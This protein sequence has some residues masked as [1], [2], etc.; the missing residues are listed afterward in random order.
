M[1][2]EE[3]VR[4]LLAL[5]RELAAPRQPALSTAQGASVQKFGLEN[6]TA[7]G[8]ALGNPQLAVPCA[9][10]AGTNGKGSTAAM[11]ECILRASGLRTG[12]YTSPHLERINERIRING[13]EISD[14]K[15][16]AAWARIRGPIEAL[17]AS[18]KLAAHPTFFECV[19]AMAFVSFADSSVDFAVYEVGM[20]GRFDA[21][22]IV[23]P[24]VAAITAIDFDHEAYLGHSIE[25]IAGEKAGII[26]PGGWVVSAAGRPEA[27]A[28]IAR[29]CDEVGA[30]LV[31]VED[32]WIIE[33]VKA[34]GGF[35]SAV[36]SPKD[37]PGRKISIA[38]ELSGRFQLQNAL[39]AATAARLLAERGFPVSDESIARGIASARW[40]GRLERISSRPAVYLDGAHNP[41]G[42]RELLRFWGENFAGRRILL[43]Y[44]AMRDKAVDEI[45]GLLFPRA[46]SVILTE[47]R[48]PRAVSAAV[49]AEI[50]GHL[51]ADAAKV[52]IVRDPAEALEHALRIAHPDDAIF[53]TGSLY[54]VG[55]LRNYWHKRAAHLAG[56]LAE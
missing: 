48:Q 15:F 17:M 41:A 25:E 45:A 39:T 35:Y 16:A 29:R 27:R 4:A 53:V 24:T 1:N 36:V 34:S 46:D 47:P 54:L 19:T 3:S 23:Q 32:A 22:N 30:R 28:V 10:I 12:L 40:P 44:G 20:G 2:Y 13:E 49:L 31:E 37:S 6:I 51:A 8:A 56:Q 26:K 52:A 21:T 42:A 38:P 18:G 11:L 9:H 55:D 50:T 43:I 33:D 7:L 5:G 14:E